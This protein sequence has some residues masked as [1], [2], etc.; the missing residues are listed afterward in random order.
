MAKIC[1]QKSGDKCTTPASTSSTGVV[2]IALLNPRIN[3]GTV[4]N[5]ASAGLKVVKGAYAK[6]PRALS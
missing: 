4:A 6:T 2:A 3:L 5:K 1:T